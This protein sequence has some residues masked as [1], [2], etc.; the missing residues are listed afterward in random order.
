MPTISPSKEAQDAI[1]DFLNGET[2]GLAFQATAA[3][4]A[5]TELRDAEW[6]SVDVIEDSEEQLQ[7]TLAEDDPTRHRILVQVTARRKPD[8]LDMTEDLKL[9]CK[10]IYQSLDQLDLED[11]RVQV[12]QINGESLTAADKEALR[13]LGLFRRNI[14]LEV[15]VLA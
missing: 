10:Q 15:E 3:D 1:V 8:G 6:I 5:K 11:G 7:E 4:V 12:W 9:L 2:F 14:V 13:T